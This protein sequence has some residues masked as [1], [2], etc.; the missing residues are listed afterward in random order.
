M[1]DTTLSPELPDGIEA[2]SHTD[3]WSM[4]SD[5]TG[6]NRALTTTSPALVRFRELLY[7]F[8]R[9]ERTGGT[10]YCCTSRDGARWSGQVNITGINGARTAA[11][12]VPVVFRDVLY[13]VFRDDYD[14]GLIKMC[15]TVDGQSWSS[16]LSISAASG[17][18][19]SS[20]PVP[21]EYNGKL[22]VCYRDDSASAGL[23]ACV[24]ATGQDWHTLID[25]GWMTGRLV[26][27]PVP[28]VHGSRM[29][30]AFVRANGKTREIFTLV[31]D[32]GDS[33]RYGGTITRGSHDAVTSCTMAT[34]AGVLYAF[35]N[36][37]SDKGR[38]V[39]N[40]SKDGVEWPVPQL[41]NGH[42]RS[43]HVPVPAVYENRLHLLFRGES[44]DAHINL[45][46]RNESDSW[47]NYTAISSRNHASANGD[48]QVLADGSR[49]DVGYRATA[50]QGK[51][52]AAFHSAGTRPWS[53]RL[54]DVPK[55]VAGVLPH[56]A[57]E[58]CYVGD[59]IWNRYNHIQSMVPYRD[60]F[61]LPRNRGLESHGTMYIVDRVG[62]KTARVMTLPEEGLNHPGGC[63]A[64]GDFLAVALEGADPERACVRFYDLS[65]LT[66]TT[67]PKL[68][69][70]RLDT[71]K[72]ANAVGITDVG[73]GSARRYVLGVYAD[74]HVAVYTSNSDRLDDPHCSFTYQFSCPTV[75]KPGPDSLTLLT[76]IHDNVW[77][78]SL[79]SK[80]TSTPLTFEDW[81]TLYK[82]DLSVQKMP[83]ASRTRFHPSSPY[84]SVLIHFRFGAGLEV[85]D[86]ESIR[87]FASDRNVD[88]G[89][90]SWILYYNKFVPRG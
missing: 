66:D 81:V 54:T 73:Y 31:S 27:A 5:I 34:Y 38:L 76:D 59:L 86:P 9:G 62:E 45:C 64:V 18:R 63:Q 71:G 25:L 39:V 89:G 46:T 17:G 57:L 79:G 50:H 40:H 19:S 85:L 2:F 1:T 32:G 3:G 7:I 43:R 21:I 58:K 49:I 37:A 14:H 26:D 22:Y 47:D 69:D 82:I 20:Q 51:G 12:I 90:T 70:L 83:L 74:G 28:I 60:W 48:L 13:V 75:V 52:L 42:N 24:S 29:V 8:Y 41:I 72:S 15:K 6:Q 10:M 16:V 11:E 53:T 56:G 30:V 33:W 68:L 65:L 44:D 35:Y 88:N 87:L 67:E 4:A 61:L 77:L 78:V 84:V 23:M 36:D 80:E 55:A